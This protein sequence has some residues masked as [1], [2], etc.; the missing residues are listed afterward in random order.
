MGEE[1]SGDKATQSVDI[2]KSVG[3]RKSRDCHMLTTNLKHHF[4]DDIPFVLEKL[5][6]GKNMNELVTRKINLCPKP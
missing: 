2:A 5:W 1:E 4:L 6:D 3:E